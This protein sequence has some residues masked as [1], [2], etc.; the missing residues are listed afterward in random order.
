MEEWFKEHG[1]EAGALLISTI[2]MVYSLYVDIR[3]RR[4]RA[5]DITREQKRFDAEML[6]QLLVKPRFDIRST[7]NRL[8]L[9]V[10]NLHTS[11]FV[12]DFEAKCTSEVSFDNKVE[13][14]SDS[15]HLETLAPNTTKEIEFQGFF[16][17]FDSFIANLGVSSFSKSVSELSLQN[18]IK[19]LREMGYLRN[20]QPSIGKLTLTWK[21]K[22]AQEG[23]QFRQAEALYELGIFEY[24]HGI[25]MNFSHRT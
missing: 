3:S 8:V 18:S 4:W 25:F 24:E 13:T 23:A 2:A 7:H 11:T 5:D 1:V 9:E 17:D 10:S 22:A 16:C 6:P 14:Q 12:R 19:T 20:G 15:L 21:Y